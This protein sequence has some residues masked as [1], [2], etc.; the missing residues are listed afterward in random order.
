VLES[1]TGATVITSHSL[2]LFAYVIAC[3]SPSLY[4]YVRLGSEIVRQYGPFI[5]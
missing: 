3:T 5:I 4:I 2:M 1:R